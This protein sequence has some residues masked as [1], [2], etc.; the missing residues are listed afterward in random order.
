[1]FLDKHNEYNLKLYPWHSV[2]M[3]KYILYLYRFFYVL[4]TSG[5]NF[6][7]LLFHTIGLHLL[8]STPKM[9]CAFFPF[10]FIQVWK[11]LQIHIKILMKS[12]A[13]KKETVYIINNR[14]LELCF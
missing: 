12:H 14:D 10:I 3:Y 9:Y 11:Y 5:Y 4:R 6:I 1:M 13:Y 7:L 8:T 2:Y